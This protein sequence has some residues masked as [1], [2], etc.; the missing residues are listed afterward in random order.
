MNVK[1]QKVGFSVNTKHSAWK[2][3]LQNRN[4]KELA[5]AKTCGGACCLIW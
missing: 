1:I 3:K 5:G 2:V 4:S